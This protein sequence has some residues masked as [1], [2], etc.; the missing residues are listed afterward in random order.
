MDCTKCGAVK[1]EIPY[2]L[3]SVNAS[4]RSPCIRD[5]AQLASGYLYSDTAG[6]HQAKA[7]KVGIPCKWRGFSASFRAHRR[8][9]SPLIKYA[10]CPHCIFED[11]SSLN[12]NSPTLRELIMPGL[13]L[14][15]IMTIGPKLISQCLISPASPSILT[16]VLNW[17]ALPSKSTALGASSKWK[18]V[19]C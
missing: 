13:M 12:C 14:P 18:Q 19:L 4:R 7:F 16:R 3:D 1:R 6:R 5:I 2:L 15:N 9:E 11:I 10:G 17:A 8:P